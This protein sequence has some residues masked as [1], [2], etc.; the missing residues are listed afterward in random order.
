MTKILQATSTI[1]SVRTH[2]QT[3]ARDRETPNVLNVHTY[4][5]IFSIRHGPVGK[6]FFY[7]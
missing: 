1:I 7:L 2:L 6:Y 4:S 5:T 3:F